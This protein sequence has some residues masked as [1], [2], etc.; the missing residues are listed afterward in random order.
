MVTF[1]HFLMCIRVAYPFVWVA[2]CLFGTLVLPALVLTSRMFL[3]QLI[4]CFI[5]PIKT[6]GRKTKGQSTPTSLTKRAKRAGIQQEDGLCHHC[7]GPDP[8]IFKAG[9]API[10]DDVG[11]KL[12]SLMRTMSVLCLSTP[13]KDCIRK[14]H[15]TYPPPLCWIVSCLSVQ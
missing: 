2:P 14:E 13:R 5:A 10:Q 6:K 1:L 3:F 4:S 8:T 15:S 12:E 9:T 11:H 7:G